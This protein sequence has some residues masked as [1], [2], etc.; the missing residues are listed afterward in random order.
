MIDAVIVEGASFDAA[1]SIATVKFPVLPRIGERITLPIDQ[2]FEVIGINHH[3]V[4]LK[5]EME[6]FV[7]V[8]SIET[9]SKYD[10]NNF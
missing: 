5:S 4:Q 7:L 6:I 1:D 3:Q 2:R 9:T 10:I 8:K